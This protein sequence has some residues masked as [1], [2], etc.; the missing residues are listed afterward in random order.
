M[1]DEYSAVTEKNAHEEGAYGIDKNKNNS[2]VP[3]QQRTSQ[4]RG[5]ADVL[6]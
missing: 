6:R 1:S 3:E 5:K 2:A 4:E